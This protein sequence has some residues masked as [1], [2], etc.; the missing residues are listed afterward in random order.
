MLVWFFGGGLQYG[1]PAEMEFD[2]ER[3]ARRGIVVVSVNYRIGVLGYMAHPQL[4]RE[5]PEAPANFGSLDQQAGLRWV[6]RNIAGFG[7]DPDN[8][9]IAGQSAGGGSVLSQISCKQNTGLFHRAVVMSAMIRDPYGVREVGRPEPLAEAEQNGVAF[10]RFIGAGSLEEARAMDAVFIRDRYAE[11]MRQCRPMF[12]VLDGRFCTGDPLAQ[13]LS[14]DCV[15]VPML[16]GNTADEFPNGLPAGDEASLAD[17]AGACF[18]ADAGRYLGFE[19]SH[20]RGEAGFGTVN[21]I[22]LTIRGVFERKA[23]QGGKNYYYCFDADIPGWD[24][25][26]TFHSVDLWFFFETLAK[27]WRPFVG[28]HYDLSRQMCNYWANFIRCGDPNGAD[29]DGTPMPEW[30]PYTSESPCVMTFT[31]EGPVSAVVPPSPFE[32]FLIDRVVDRI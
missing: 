16:A 11:Y 10:L 14:G 12:T 21:G 22:G 17:A 6:K 32:R 18:G 28:R 20:V 7:G 8:V 24:H 25:P 4:T 19:E 27:C 15:N 3:L 30:G 26:G 13:Y 5:Q 9:T 2:G 1:Y 29:A 23:R 31:G